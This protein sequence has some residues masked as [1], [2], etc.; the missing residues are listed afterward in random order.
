MA[1]DRKRGASERRRAEWRQVEP[2]SAIGETIAIAPDHLDL[3][4]QR[5]AE[6]MGLRDL[7][8]SIP[9]LSLGRLAFGP[10]HSACCSSRIAA[11]SRSM[12]SRTQS[13]K[14]VAI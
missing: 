8:M 11:S 13:R 6:G 10:V 7:Q 12:A 5:R 14:S 1:I 9:G 4:H 2:A 3:G